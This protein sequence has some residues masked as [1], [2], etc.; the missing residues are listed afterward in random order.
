MSI[1][2]KLKGSGISFGKL[3]KGTGKATD[4]TRRNILINRV[5]EWIRYNEDDN[6]SHIATKK[7]VKVTVL[8]WGSR[9]RLSE[10][11]GDKRRIILPVGRGALHFDKDEA[12]FLDDTSWAA[13]KAMFEQL[14]ELILA[15]DFDAEI[16]AL[17]EASSAGL[18]EYQAREAAKK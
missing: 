15:K 14:K 5:N 10:V 17:T 13:E 2:A 8:G 9:T 6:Y 18:R 3:V 1:K 7:K 12:L 4:E 11:V 16:K